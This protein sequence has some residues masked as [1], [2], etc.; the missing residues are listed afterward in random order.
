VSIN[1]HVTSWQLRAAALALTLLLLDAVEAT[2]SHGTPPPPPPP[3]HGQLLVRLVRPAGESGGLPDGQV[4]VEAVELH[5]AGARLD[6]WVRLPLVRTK[7][8]PAELQGGQVWLADV[9]LPA[10]EYDQVR[11]ETG[12]RSQIAISIALRLLPGKWTIL[13]L[14]V[15][16]QPGRWQGTLRLTVNQTRTEG[17]Y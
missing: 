17:P 8:A 3:G 1:R 4:G 13:S 16:F 6:E 15:G 7:F 5:R 11:V 2:A 14:E 10:A 9:P 12:G